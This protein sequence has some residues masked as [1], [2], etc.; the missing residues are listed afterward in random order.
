M[1]LLF[2]FNSWSCLAMHIL[3]SVCIPVNNISD[4][5][6]INNHIRCYKILYAFRKS[7]YGVEFQF[8]EIWTVVGRRRL[9]SHGKFNKRLSKAGDV[10]NGCWSLRC[11]RTIAG[12]TCHRKYSTRNNCMFDL[13]ISRTHHLVL[14]TSPGRTVLLS[15]PCSNTSWRKPK[16]SLTNRTN[17]EGER[18]QQYRI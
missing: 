11:W 15:P 7:P 17:S 9:R 5:W 12:K 2:S 3:A 1:Q 16:Y 14:V 10:R 4:I 6:A 8:L 13:Q 18:A